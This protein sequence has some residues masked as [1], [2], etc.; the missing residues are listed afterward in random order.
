MATSAPHSLT[1]HVIGYSAPATQV[2][3]PL[4]LVTA[5]TQGAGSSGLSI[6]KALSLLSALPLSRSAMR[7]R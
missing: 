5:T 2:S 7:I 1:V 4:G 6:V 3:P